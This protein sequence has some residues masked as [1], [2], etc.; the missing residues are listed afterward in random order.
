MEVEDAM[1]TG[2]IDEDGATEI[3]RQYGIYDDEYKA[4]LEEKYGV[5]FDY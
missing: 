2:Q 4:M 5:K 3:L 1:E